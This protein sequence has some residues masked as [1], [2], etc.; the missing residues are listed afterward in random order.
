MSLR[1]IGP[2]EAR[3]AYC[4]AWERGQLHDEHS[5]IIKL[6]YDNTVDAIT[7]C[8][9]GKVMFCIDLVEWKKIHKS[10]EEMI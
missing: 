1:V 10:L 2:I 3:C 5:H 7:F 4:T 9:D 6:D 8:L